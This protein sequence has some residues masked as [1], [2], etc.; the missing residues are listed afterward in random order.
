MICARIFHSRVFVIGVLGAF[1]VLMAPVSEFAQAVRKVGVL[2]GSVRAEK[3]FSAANVTIKIRNL[4][5]EKEFSTTSDANGNYR[6]EDVD[7][8]WY[9]LTVTTPQQDFTLSYGIYV[10]AADAT[11]VNLTM[12]ANGI[13]EGKGGAGSARG[14]SFFKKPLGI[15][16]LVVLTAGIGLGITQLAKTKQTIVINDDTLNR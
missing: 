15:L 16:T 2:T 4:N 11:R 1:L 7:E 12:R 10:K 6:I 3:G 8:G 14:K 5:T 13:L 9:T